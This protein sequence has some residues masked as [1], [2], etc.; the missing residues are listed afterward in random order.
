M[1]QEMAIGAFGVS[2]L[3]SVILRMIYGTFEVNSRWKPW[4]A[5]IIGV[6]LGMVVMLYNLAPGST[7]GFRL[8]VEHV[9]G[10]FMTGATATGMYEMTKSKA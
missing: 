4:I 7:V 3:L 1:G 5:V 6:L 10:G 9:L 2:L 8:I